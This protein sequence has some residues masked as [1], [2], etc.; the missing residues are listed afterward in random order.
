MHGTERRNNMEHK[1]WATND[2]YDIFNDIKAAWKNDDNRP[3]DDY[4]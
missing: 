2:L 1:I 3:D 4:I